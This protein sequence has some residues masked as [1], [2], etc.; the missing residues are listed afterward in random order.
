MGLPQDDST[1]DELYV[2]QVLS[3]LKSMTP[4]HERQTEKFTAT[5]YL[6]NKS[7]PTHVKS[8]KLSSVSNKIGLNKCEVCFGPQ[9][10]QIWYIILSH[11]VQWC[12]CLSFSPLF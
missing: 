7:W 1:D 11:A 9:D 5:E 3:T 8:N 10:Y 4:K 2:E 12:L 6:S